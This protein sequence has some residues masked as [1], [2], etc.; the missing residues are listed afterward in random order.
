MDSQKTLSPPLL[1]TEGQ[2]LPPPDTRRPTRPASG[3]VLKADP[4]RVEN[5][6]SRGLADTVKT[7]L[8]EIKE[9]DSLRDIA[10]SERYLP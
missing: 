8:R 9:E 4:E 7:I 5:E 2:T 3:Q 6:W 1:E 10:E